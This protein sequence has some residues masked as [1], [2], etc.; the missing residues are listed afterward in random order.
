[1]KRERERECECAFTRVV[2][3]VSALQLRRVHANATHVTHGL[4]ASRPLFGCN[5]KAE[6]FTEMQ[7][8]AYRAACNEERACECAFTGV[9]L[10]ACA[11]RS[12]TL[13]MRARNH[14]LH[15]LSHPLLGG[16]WKAGDEHRSRKCSAEPTELLIN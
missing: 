6:L 10:A 11:Y 12:Q 8:G 14:T 2:L 16:N 1:M 15:S 5:R 13:L 4:H 9:V 7:C 3:E